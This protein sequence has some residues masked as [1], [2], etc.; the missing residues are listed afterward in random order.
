[1][2]RGLKNLQNIAASRAP[3]KTSDSEGEMISPPALDEAHDDS[4]IAMSSTAG[5]A[6]VGT[7]IESRRTSGAM[8]G[9]NQLLH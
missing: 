9:W 1:M 7:G 5:S 8:P 3:K 2:E 4:G 6:S